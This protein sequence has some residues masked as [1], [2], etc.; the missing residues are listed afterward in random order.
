[1]M[2][3]DAGLITTAVCCY[4]DNPLSGNPGTYG[5]PVGTDAAYGMIGAPGGYAMIAQR[6][7]TEF[8]TTSEQLGAV[9]VSTRGWASKNPNAHKRDPLTL[10]DHQASRY[11][12]W[13]LHLLD[14]CLVSDGGAAVVVT[15]ADRARHLRKPPVYVMGIGQHH[16]AW[17]LPHRPTLTTSGAKISG[18]KAFRMAGIGPGDIDVCEIYDCFTIVPIIT[19]EDYGF[20]AKGEGGAFVADG[21]TGPDGSL[22]MNT[23]G[24]LLSESGMAGMQLL[25]EG[26][27]QLRGECGDRQVKGAETA[28]DQRPGRHHAHPRY[29]SPAE[30]AHDHRLR[31]TPARN[32]CRQPALLGGL[33]GAQTPPPTLFASAAISGTPH[34]FAPSA[35]L[36]TTIGSSAQGT[37]PFTP[38]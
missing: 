26:V 37:V 6:H 3:I 22:P 32:H 31:Q 9:A 29:G 34:P 30:I 18:E 35:G 27:R 36:P 17:D 1:M 11:V 15:S 2:A 10:E 14:C 7:M 23:G 4:G 13:P 19:L 5:R 8:G 12:T 20:C 24:G 28:A 25:V 16:I 21:R 38:G 33:Q